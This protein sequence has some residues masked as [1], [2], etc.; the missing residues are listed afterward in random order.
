MFTRVY[1]CNTRSRSSSSSWF[2]PQSYQQTTAHRSPAS[3]H[4]FLAII[5]LLFLGVANPRQEVIPDYCSTFICLFHFSLIARL[6]QSAER[7]ANNAVATGS[8]PV[9]SNFFAFGAPCFAAFLSRTTRTNNLTD[10]FILSCASAVNQDQGRKNSPQN[11]L[12]CQHFS[13]RTCR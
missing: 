11:Q 6:A 7:C 2:K 8:I 9:S 4:P 3:S 5:P 12:I 1:F 10:L 13:P